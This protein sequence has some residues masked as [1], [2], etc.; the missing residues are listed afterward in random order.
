MNNGRIKALD[1][2]CFLNGGCMLD[3]S[4]LVRA[5]EKGVIL[6][7]NPRAE[8][9]DESLQ[10]MFLQVLTQV[11][12]AVRLLLDFYRKKEVLANIY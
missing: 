12:Q 10:S 6:D 5:S 9:P 8:F 1:I 4:E 7:P 2:E 3:D 11:S